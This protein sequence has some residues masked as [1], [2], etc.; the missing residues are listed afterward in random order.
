LISRLEQG[1]T[2]PNW[3]TIEQLAAALQRRARLRL[4]PDDA[5][6]DA[7]A[8]RIREMKP[9]DRLRAQQF[10]VLGT[11]ATIREFGV[12]FVLTGA[13]AA[14]L[15]GFP[16]PIEDVRI[17]VH[18]TD[19]AMGALERL[20][21]A[22]QLLFREFGPDELRAIV[23]RSWAIVDCDVQITLVDE[24]PDSLT[25]EL[26]TDFEVRVLPPEALLADEEVAS[27]LGVVQVPSSES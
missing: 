27:M 4:V 20:L 2:N 3:R 9:I 8:A 24:L 12:P 13:V 5:A 16:T 23:Q 7:M 6:V 1:R 10:N 22:E 15:Q 14:L 11:I 25:V 21:L 26:M 17:L 19:A 18:D